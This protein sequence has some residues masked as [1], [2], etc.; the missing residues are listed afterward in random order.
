MLNIADRVDNNEKEEAEKGRYCLE[1]MV[2]Y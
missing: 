2:V 1:K